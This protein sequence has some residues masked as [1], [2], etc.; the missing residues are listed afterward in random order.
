MR[1]VS[2]ETIN[3]LRSVRHHQHPEVFLMTK[4]TER[5]F[6]KY[7]SDTCDSSKAGTLNMFGIPCESYE[8]IEECKE[9]ARELVDGL[10]RVTILT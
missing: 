9:R 6:R 2:Y 7:I 3:L 5:S 4:E 10:R 8:T 1:D